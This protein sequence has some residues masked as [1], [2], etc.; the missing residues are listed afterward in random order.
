MI[1]YIFISFLSMRHRTK[2]AQ[3]QRS[4]DTKSSFKEQYYYN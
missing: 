1:Q 2:A 3:F 4:K